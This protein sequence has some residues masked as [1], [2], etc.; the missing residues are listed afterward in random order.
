VDDWFDSTFV[1]GKYTAPEVLNPLS[2]LPPS[3]QATPGEDGFL[4]IYGNDFLNYTVTTSWTQSTLNR[5]RMATRGASQNVALEVSV[6]VSDLEF[7]KLTYNGEIFYPVP[8]LDTWTLRLRTELG[9]GGGYGGTDELP[10]Y[11]NFFAGGFGSVRGYKSNTLGPQSTPA[12]AYVVAQPVTAINPDGT[13][14]QI[15]GPDGNEVGYVASDQALLYNQVNTNGSDSFG[16]NV[17]VVGSAEL[18][19]PLPFIKDQ[20]QLRTG[21]FL[22]AGNVY[23]TDCGATQVNCFDVDL[24]ELRYS[25][26]VGLTW[27]T[28]FGPMSFSLAK[29]LNSNE[30]DEEEIFQFTLGRGF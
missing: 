18:L 23:N 17:M 8:V 7:Y 3:Y 22:D 21:F 1:D 13:A 28:G 6:P 20:S 2:T 29:P 12:Q 14:A 9:Y 4:N 19:F 30:F 24:N 26:G 5:G 15:G 11:E 10:F 25:A 16:G 27:I